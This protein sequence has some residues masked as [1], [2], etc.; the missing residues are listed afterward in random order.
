MKK[1]IN[2]LAI[3]TLAFLSA[4]DLD[5]YPLTSYNQ[6]NVKVDQNTETQYSTRADMLGLRNTM[7]NDWVKDI[8]ENGYMDWLVNTECHSDN[9]YCGGGATEIITVEANTQ[10]SEN[11]NLTRDWSWYLG[12]VSNANQIICNIDNI[13]AN[14]TSST[15]MTETEHHQWKAEALCWRAWNLFQ[16]SQ[17]WGD[18]PMVTTIPPAIT[19]DNIEQ[20]YSAYF[21][22]RTPRADV[23]RQLIEDLDYA[24]Q[25]APDVDKSNK[26]LFTKAFAHGMLARIYAEKTAQDWGKV[27]E[28]CQ[29]VEDMGFSLVSRYGD[30]WK[31]DATDANRNTSESIF[32]VTYARDNG[33]WVWM[34]FHRNAY[35]PDDS[36]SWIKWVTPS[37]NLIAAY[38]AEGDTARMNA[39]IAWDSCNWSNYYPSKHYAFM[40]KV[41]T[42]ATSIILMRLA[43]IYLLHAEALTETNDLTGAAGYVNKVRNRAGLKNLPT[44]VTAN[45]TA[46][47]KAVLNERRLELAFEGFR[48]YDLVRHDMAKEVCEALTN[49]SSSVYDSYWYP[50]SPY[51]NENLLMP[52]PQ[53]D[54]DNNPS[55]VQNPGY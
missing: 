52:V 30:L 16:M 55:L 26:L 33:N 3:S 5:Q 36:Y 38:Q 7:Y 21:P 37:R 32:E 42:N 47:V 25:Y 18:V 13:A 34:M 39:N 19:A 40:N 23:Y 50:R 15:K 22:A 9:A 14:D 17:L 48:F 24:C 41:P 29:A 10:D 46:M 6:G 31:Y 49:P 35:N 51:T 4:C 12:Q 2:I 8:Q 28:N 53:T 11:Y 20:V 1:I 43:E 54:L 44:S 27:I 45:K